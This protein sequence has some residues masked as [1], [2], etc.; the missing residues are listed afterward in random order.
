MCRPN[1]ANLFA[2]YDCTYTHIDTHTPQPR[3]FSFLLLQLMKIAFRSIFLA[4]HLRRA[5]FQNILFCGCRKPFALSLSLSLIHNAHVRVPL[6]LHAPCGIRSHLPLLAL[7]ATATFSSSY[8]RS[9]LSACVSN[10]E[11]S[12]LYAVCVNRLA[13][14]VLCQ[15][16]YKLLY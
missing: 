3:T 10:T 9:C 5:I 6:C 12:C 11:L 13:L 7:L 8:A 15:N 4:F 2:A 14:S 1:A 16:V